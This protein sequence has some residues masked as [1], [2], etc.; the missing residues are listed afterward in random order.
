MYRI[1]NIIK[2]KG[3]SLNQ[4]RDH[5]SIPISKTALHSCLNGQ[6]PKH[7]EQTALQN[8]ILEACTS[9]GVPE[10]DLKGAWKKSAPESEVTPTQP[11][12]DKLI[13]RRRTMIGSEIQKHLGLT[14]DPFD[15]E[16]DSAEDVMPTKQHQRVLSRMLDAARNCKFL[17]VVGPVGS[18]KT[19]VKTL[20][21]EKPKRKKNFPI[22]EPHIISKEKCSPTNIITAMTDDFLYGAK[23]TEAMK[24]VNPMRGGD[25][26]ERSRW[27]HA[28][29]RLKISEGK[30]LVLLIDVA[31]GLREETLRSLKRFHELQEGFKKLI[32]IILVGQEELMNVLHGNYALREVSARINIV[33]MKPINNLVDDYLTHKLSRAGVELIKVMDESA[34]KTVKRLLPKAVPLSV[35]NLASRSIEE[36][37]NL[38]VWPV[39]GDIVETAYRSFRGSTA[40]PSE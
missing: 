24:N 30:K 20:F 19:I 3:V 32:S 6:W 18:G 9:V 23:R 12:S 27:V 26:E 16:I 14:R 10:K 40:R 21:I 13:L 4:V 5:M 31:H 2:A 38:G 7:Q 37:Y 17:A 8:D 22:S 33:E 39:T 25:L 11:S 29:L 1:K 35:N 34:I 36:A 28:L 15:N